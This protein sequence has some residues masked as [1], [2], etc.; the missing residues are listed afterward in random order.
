M[1]NDVAEKWVEDVEKSVR[2]FS[3]KHSAVYSK[4]DRQL[5]ASFEIGCFLALIGMYEFRGFSC[6]ACNLTDQKEYRYLTSPNGN[7]ANFSY[8]LAKS[9]AEDCEVRQQVRVR[10]HLD[11]DIAFTPDIVVI[12]TDSDLSGERDL[13]YAGGKRRFFSVSA[14]DVIAAHEC[15]SLPPFPELLVSFVGMLIAAHPWLE[16]PTD[17]TMV[18][19]RGAHLAPTL[20]VGGTARS[21]HRRMVEA[22]CQTYPMNAILGMHRG[23]WELFEQ[24]EESL[25]F[26]RNPLMMDS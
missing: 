20:F 2:A 1:R 12:R 13:D 18:V 21:L 24:E 15:K 9:D 22:L 14:N 10:S 26:I 8:I 19:K 25:T 23:T 3:K 5:F 11:P 6:I 16:G 17:R 4:T 7:P